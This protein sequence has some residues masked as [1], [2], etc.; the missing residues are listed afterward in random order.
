[1]PGEDTWHSMTDAIATATDAGE[2]VAFV[3][4]MIAVLAG[5]LGALVWSLDPDFERLERLGLVARYD[6][7]IS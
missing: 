1:M 4:V 5:E 7:P 3:D 6:P 2:R